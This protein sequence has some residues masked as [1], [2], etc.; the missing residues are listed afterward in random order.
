MGGTVGIG[1][2]GSFVTS[3]ISR[4]TDALFNS[5]LSDAVPE[6]LLSR[7]K[8]N[9]ENLFV[10]EVQRLLSDKVQTFLQQA[11]VDGVSILFWIVLFTSLLSLCLCWWLPAGKRTKP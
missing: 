1:I 10:P 11:I 8:E 9:I 6:P 2:C 3:K 5:G 4:I 7:I